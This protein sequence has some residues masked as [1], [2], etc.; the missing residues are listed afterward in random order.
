MIVQS[1]DGHK[2][3]LQLN[4]S[5]F[6]DFQSALHKQAIE[7]IHKLYPFISITEEV[8]INITRYKTLYLDIFLAKFD[9]AI[10]IHGAQHFKFI[11]HFHTTKANFY[12][13]QRND[14][15]KK[16]WCEIN[17]IQLIELLYDESID[18]WESKLR[19]IT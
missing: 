15:L 4:H 10:E 1:L 8:S 7:L 13:Q 2:S 14:E 17:N 19:R 6:N 12:K 18:E 11:Q 9:T 5:I 16:Q 3:K